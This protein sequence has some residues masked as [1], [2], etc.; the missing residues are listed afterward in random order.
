[1]AHTCH[2]TKCTNK[3]PEKM[4]MCK[5]HWFMLPSF[6]RDQIWR[7]YKEGQEERKDPTRLYCET[8]IEC[9]KYIARLE[10]IEPDVKLYEMMMPE[11]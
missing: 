11:V 10:R 8:A 2:A 7:H 5:H 6:L 1:M 9:V 4:F 3:V